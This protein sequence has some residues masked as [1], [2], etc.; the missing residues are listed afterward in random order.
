MQTSKRREYTLQCH[1]TCHTLF[2]LGPITVLITD[3]EG[4]VRSDNKSQVYDVLVFCVRR[5]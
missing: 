4:A 2:Y 3:Y 1:A 5:A